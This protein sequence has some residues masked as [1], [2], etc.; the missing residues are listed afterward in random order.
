MNIIKKYDEKELILSIEGRID[1]ITSK[2]L[3]KEIDNEFGKFNSLTMDFTDLN[4]ISSAGLRVLI[5]TQKKLKKEDI[6]FSIKNVNDAV[7]EIFKMSGFDKIL[8]IE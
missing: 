5:V 6:P 1:T 8:R 3:E 7:G 2:D 4:Y